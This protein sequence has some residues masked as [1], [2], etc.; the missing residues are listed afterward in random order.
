MVTKYQGKEDVRKYLDHNMK[1]SKEQFLVS[2]YSKSKNTIFEGLRVTSA[3]TEHPSEKRFYS[4]TRDD[5]YPRVLVTL[6]LDDIIYVEVLR[7]WEL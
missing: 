5:I 4:F 7:Q 6:E 2:V 1:S 3:R